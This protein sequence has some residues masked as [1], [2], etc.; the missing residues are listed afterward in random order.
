MVI[1]VD[2]AK[3]SIPLEIFHPVESNDFIEIASAM[4]KGKFFIVN[5]SKA[6]QYNGQG[7]RLADNISGACFVLN[8]NIAR[9]CNYALLVTPTKFPITSEIKNKISEEFLRRGIIW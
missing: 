8:L 6:N 3:N 4:E 5:L 2:V 1:D 9:I 7:Q